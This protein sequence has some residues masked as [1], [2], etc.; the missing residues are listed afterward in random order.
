MRGCLYQIWLKL[1]SWLCRKLTICF[2]F[3]IFFILKGGLVFHLNKTESF[4][5]MLRLKL[6]MEEVNRW[7]EK[8]Q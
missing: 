2:S 4:L 8:Q 7:T 5:P 6:G 3:P 1:A